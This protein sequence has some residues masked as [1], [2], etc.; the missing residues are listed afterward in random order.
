MHLLRPTGLV[1]L[2]FG[3]NWIQKTETGINLL[4]LQ[5]VKDDFLSMVFICAYFANFNLLILKLKNVLG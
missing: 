2:Y 1:K 5:D 4:D 3:S